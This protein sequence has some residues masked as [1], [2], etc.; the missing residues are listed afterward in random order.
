MRKG[1]LILCMAMV[2]SLVG[3]GAGSSAPASAPETT[4]AVPE[5][6]E[7]P[8]PETEPETEAPE[9]IPDIPYVSPRYV[10]KLQ[11]KDGTLCGENGE[12]VQL[13]GVSTAAITRIDDFLNQDLFVEMRRDWGVNVVRLAMYVLAQDGYTKSEYY[14]D[15]N[16]ELV[17]RG[18]E[19]AAQTDM[20]VIIDWHVLDDRN[21][22]EFVDESVEFFDEMSA[23]YKDYNNVIYEICNEPNRCEWADIKEYA[24]RVIPVIRAN[25]PDSVII[26]GTPDWSQGVDQA[27]ADPVEF[28]N[29]MY[30]LHFYSATHKDELRDRMVEC[31]EAGLPIFVT[32]YGVTASNGG[33]PRD[34][35]EA[36]RWM[37]ALDS[38]NI[39]CCIWS[40][41]KKGEAC[42]L[43][44]S[45]TKTFKGYTEENFSETGLWFLEML[46]KYKENLK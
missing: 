40:L 11:V 41:S 46:A 10:G 24:E 6:T 26:C 28:D 4:E 22:M 35:E 1:I 15:R 16:K 2:L 9:L 29:L 44:L 45:Q 42:N 3:C 21:P 38:H 5:T 33:F 12:P 27:L 31:S 34:L 7:A 43:I 25:D 18:V 8:A 14:H 36:D 19:L 32:E 37:E 20:Y 17:Q 39:S 30:T 13:K 23:A